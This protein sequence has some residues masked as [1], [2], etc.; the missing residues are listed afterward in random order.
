MHIFTV[1]GSMHIVK[2]VIM[3]YIKFCWKT[4]DVYVKTN[5]TKP[6]I[7]SVSLKH[8][9]YVVHYTNYMN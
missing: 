8:C 7:T 1:N 4:E 6:E 5:N 2:L 3:E 9:K